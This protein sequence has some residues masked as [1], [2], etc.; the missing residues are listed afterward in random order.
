MKVY[1]NKFNDSF[2]L[3]VT[4]NSC[5]DEL[6]YQVAVD[7][8]YGLLSIENTVGPGP[9]NEIYIT[10]PKVPSNP[11]AQGTLYAKRRTSGE[12]YI[13]ISVPN[14]IFRVYEDGKRF[15]LFYSDGSYSG[16]YVDLIGYDGEFPD[17]LIDEKSLNALLGGSSLPTA[18]TPVLLN[19]NS[20]YSISTE[21]ETRNFIKVQT[22]TSVKGRQTASVRLRGLQTNVQIFLYEFIID[23]VDQ[24]VKATDQPPIG[25]KETKTSQLARSFVPVS[26]V[27]TLQVDSSGALYMDKLYSGGSTAQTGYRRRCTNLGFEKDL[28]R[29][30]SSI[31]KPSLYSFSEE[32]FKSSTQTLSEQYFTDV[33]TGVLINR[34]TEEGFRFFAPL[35]L[36]DQVPSYFA[37]FKKGATSSGED[38]LKDASLVTLI[39]I[40]KTELGPYLNGLIQNENFVKAP[41][42]VSIDQGYS[43]KW[44][45]VSVD[46]GYWITH[47]EFIGIDIQQG[48]SDFEFNK[49]LSGGFSRGSIVNPQF[50]NIEFLFNDNDS[51]LYD[52]NQYFG[53]Y[54]DDIELSRFIPNVDSTSTLFRQNETRQ[55]TNSDFNSS[56]ISNSDG[57]KLVVD[58]NETPDRNFSVSDPSTMLVDS[59][60]VSSRYPIEISATTSSSRTLRVTFTS[61]IDITQKLSSGSTVRLEDENRNFVS[62]VTVGTSSYS[63]VN[64]K[65]TINFVENDT[66]SR[67]GLDYWLNIFDFSPDASPSIFGGMRF[68]S[69]N[70]GKSRCVVVSKNDLA[71]NKI[72]K[73]IESVVDQGSMFKDSLVLFDKSSSAYAI[74][75]ANSITVEEDYIKVFFDV[76]ESKDPFVAGDEVFMNVSEY[77]VDGAIPGPSVVNSSTRKFLLKTK[78]DAYSVKNFEFSNYK[79]S[80]VGIFSLDS[81]T[82]N[83]GSIVGINSSTN[84]PVETVDAPY[85]GIGLKFPSIVTESIAYG[86]RITVEQKIGGSRRMWS[87][88]RSQQA[89]PQV[90]KI[91]GAV[92][93]VAIVPQTFT[94]NS[95]YTEF[96]IDSD[97]YFPVRFDSFELV[98][99]TSAQSNTQLKFVSAEQQDNGNHLLT[100]ANKNVVSDYQAV[101]VSIPDTDVTYFD[102]TPSNSLETVVAI[103]FQRF[104][105]CPFRSATADG[106]LYLYSPV[107][108]TDISVGIYLSY[109]TINQMEINGANLQPTSVVKDSETLFAD[110]Y[111][112]S[113]EPL[114]DKKVYSVE[115]SFLSLL[116]SGTKILS[117]S[118]TPSTLAEWNNRSYGVP[119][120]RSI[121]EDGENRSLIRFDGNNEPSLLNGRLQL[122]NTNTVSLSLVSFYDLIDLDFFDEIPVRLGTETNE[123]RASFGSGASIFSQK[124]STINTINSATASSNQKTLVLSV[125]VAENIYSD[126][127]TWDPSNNPNFLSYGTLKGTTSTDPNTVPVSW[128]PSYGFKIQYLNPNGQ[129]VDYQLSYPTIS[130]QTPVVSFSVAHVRADPMWQL[131][132]S[133]PTLSPPSNQS[134][135]SIQLIL[136]TVL[137]Y[138][139]DASFSERLRG[140][141]EIK[142][143]MSYS[144]KELSK[145]NIDASTSYAS[146]TYKVVLSIDDE[147]RD[148]KYIAK[149][150][151]GTYSVRE[152][153]VISVVGG[154]PEQNKKLAGV[155]GENIVSNFATSL[156]SLQD[157]TRMTLGRWKKRNSTNVDFMPYLINVDPLLL[158]YD[159]FVNATEE[160]ISTSTFSLDWYL[161]SGWPKFDSLEN[162]NKNY[163]YI[164]NRVGLDELKSTDYDYFTYYLTVGHGEEVFING[165]EREKKFLWTDIESTE[166]GYTT[167]FKGIPLQF[168]SPKVNLQGTKFAAILQIE[169]SLDVPTKVSLVYNQQ[170]NALTLLVQI[171]IDSYLIDGSIGLEQLYQLRTNV[172]RT[173][174]SVLYGPMMVYGTDTLSFN[175]VDR[176]YNEQEI[177]VTN[178]PIPLEDY[179]EY[180]QY[181]YNK[182]TTIKYDESA[183]D[184]EIFGVKYFPNVDYLVTGTIF[185]G[186]KNETQVSF[187][188]PKSRVRGVFDPSIGQERMFIDG[189]YGDDFFA[190]VADVDGSPI[191]T[192]ATFVSANT[193]NIN[194]SLIIS[195]S[196]YTGPGP[197][198]VD[199]STMIYNS[200]VYAIGDWPVYRD[201]IEQVSATSIMSRM[202]ASDFDDILV[203]TDS[204][205][206]K[207]NMSVSYLKPPVLRP[208]M[209]KNAAI[210]E[211]GNITILDRENTTNLFRLDGGFEPSYK[212]VLGFAA[213][214]DPS[215]TK[216]LL[217]S[218]RGY[219][220]QLIGVNKTNIWYRRVSDQGVNTGNINVNGN[221]LRVPYALGRKIE[222]PLVD[223]WGE[224]FY[225]NATDN[226]IDVP[227]DGIQN[228]KDQ[229]FFLSSKAMSVPSFFRTSNYSCMDSSVPSNSI[230]AAVAYISGQT[231]LTIQVDFEKIISDHLFNAGVFGFFSSIWESIGTSLSPYDISKEYI[232]R[233]LLDRYIVESIDVYQKPSQRTEVVSIIGRPETE[234]FTFINAIGIEA[235]RFFDFSIPIDGSK[236]I[237]LAF[238]IKRR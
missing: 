74:L 201:V 223:T 104:I 37:I 126:W 236:Q 15:Y 179:Y 92:T 188:I 48:L 175:K 3:P 198:V 147:H 199:S 26:S 106:T 221:I 204:S 44:N 110:Y 195:N 177:V 226:F 71:G 109:G 217:N 184:I 96:E 161:I 64:K 135:T 203:S 137:E 180:N 218:L 13:E 112:Y 23:P 108:Q 85:T 68:D 84:I 190:V 158:P 78:T 138:M 191:A 116:E 93:E 33:N 238:N 189:L 73:W 80:V 159:L 88:V 11:I 4:N 114:K 174:E 210:D 133:D 215:I 219:N 102:Y 34:E 182:V 167:M 153:D 140:F 207:T 86:D 136:D 115:G 91:P 65:M 166:N 168:S 145:E 162:V 90:S 205:I 17:F 234:G 113:I 28:S 122:I 70:V 143:L 63:S 202:S 142:R 139:S 186:T 19:I 69:Q 154:K 121:V 42:D 82:F 225:S 89:G 66:Y 98:N 32:D 67:L 107:S 24:V 58:L 99:S 156:A 8:T 83:L 183:K 224:G 129:W 6:G 193:I 119:N 220:T 149:F 123:A 206:S 194:G 47:T 59:I 169:E 57:V 213:S 94:T 185:S 187:I 232:E 235:I 117:K 49:I 62:Y 100:F 155:P 7:D 95:S 53:M 52:V 41:L 127:A 176:A 237:V 227:I 2:Y 61:D 45:G 157:K 60:K 178:Q 148:Y 216:Q 12:Y 209:T 124:R 141:S 181:Q 146:Y 30:C 228:P 81:K 38:L 214:E 35:W 230:D 20:P 172:A 192:Y 131:T 51:K 103:A 21:F 39:D 233:N 1:T 197:V 40:Q 97:S 170:W 22:S 31:P 196:Y 132:F 111:T 222:S 164:G 118:G 56:V 18:S 46:S 144:F 16:I 72:E 29:F 101:R 54:C 163:Q 173:D 128:N 79:N 75:L 151:D 55:S 5:R 229:K 200:K 76:I 25:I 231:R 134:F 9:K 10:V 212:N 14:P 87:V 171:S 50:L 36:K 120:I 150:P 208:L 152:D 43:L 77:D 160:G 27:V 165:A 130:M 105:D 211:F 125:N